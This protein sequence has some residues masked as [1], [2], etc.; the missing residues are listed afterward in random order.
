MPTVHEFLF[1]ILHSVPDAFEKIY[2]MNIVYEF[3]TSFDISG[4]F[5]NSGDIWRNVFV[6]D[7]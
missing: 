3:E 2:F 5:L 1:N 7:A 6:I 4:F